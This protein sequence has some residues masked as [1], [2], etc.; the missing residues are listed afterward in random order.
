MLGSKIR[1]RRPRM[2]KMGAQKRIEI[3]ERDC[4]RDSYMTKSGR[5]FRHFI[6]LSKCAFCRRHR[7]SGAFGAEGWWWVFGIENS[8]AKPVMKLYR[9][10]SFHFF[11]FCVRVW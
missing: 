1:Y 6:D 10:N 11:L 3:L 4:E 9:Y 7:G 5:T 8:K 2:E